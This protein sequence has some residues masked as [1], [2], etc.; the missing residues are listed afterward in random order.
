MAEA[1]R[2]RLES[3]GFSPILADAETVD[4][5]WLLSNAVGGIKVQVPKAE[6]EQARAALRDIERRSDKAD[7][8]T[9][10]T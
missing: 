1:V 9:A 10:P 3:E 5:D 8:R 6:V 2:L 7:G 4:M